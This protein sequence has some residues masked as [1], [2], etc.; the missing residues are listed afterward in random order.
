MSNKSLYIFKETAQFTFMI[1]YVTASH[2]KLLQNVTL[3]ILIN[4]VIIFDTQALDF[5]E[6]CQH[7]YR[8]TV[9][10]VMYF[11]R[12]R[13]YEHGHWCSPLTSW[14]LLDFFEKSPRMRRMRHIF[15]FFSF[16]FQFLQAWASLFIERKI[17]ESWWTPPQLRCS[18]FAS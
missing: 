6:G 7:E 1:N 17:K 13:E 16:S 14:N 3:L 2:I 10:S 15:F 5:F 4:K 9:V 8:N 11:L 18:L 12:L